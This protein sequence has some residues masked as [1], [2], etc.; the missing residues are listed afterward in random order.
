[1]VV[2]ALR[3]CCWV[4]L[5]CW[6]SAAGRADWWSVG[7]LRRSPGVVGG[8]DADRLAELA[9]LELAKVGGCQLWFDVRGSSELAVQARR[10]RTRHRCR[11]V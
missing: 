8:N 3:R 10:G 9:W 1:M 11:R 6:A 7:R 5:V 2:I 4:G